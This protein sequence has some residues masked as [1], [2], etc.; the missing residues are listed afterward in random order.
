MRILFLVGAPLLAL[1]TGCADET[2]PGVRKADAPDVED[3]DQLP[4]E[5]DTDEPPSDTGEPAEPPTDVREICYLGN[6]RGY[7]TC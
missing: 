5:L 4:D 1:S 3:T 7:T 2:T 6:D